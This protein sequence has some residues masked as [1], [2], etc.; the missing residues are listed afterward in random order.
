MN[1]IDEASDTLLE[2][3]TETAQAVPTEENTTKPEGKTDDALAKY[4]NED[5]EL[6]A[7]AVMV[8]LRQSEERLEGLRKKLAD[9]EVRTKA[10]EP[11]PEKAVPEKTAPT[12]ADEMKEELEAI[13][14]EKDR[15]FAE[16]FIGLLGKNGLSKE[17]ANELLNG[18][19]ELY[20]PEDPKAFFQNEMKKLGKGGK[21][22]LT[23][24]RAFRDSMRD[25]KEFGEEE[26]ASLEQI[27]QTADGV[28]LI[29]RV[30]EKARTMDSGKFS[31]ARTG[32]FSADDFSNADRIK[33]YEKAFALR[34]T[35]P[36]ESEAEIARLDRMF[37]K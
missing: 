14:D 9:K 6:D 33:M 37:A 26:I 22:V 3:A 29:D 20:Q 11:A 12:L 31:H 2:E 21:E 27:T 5:G 25:S 19:T 7:D 17:K 35:N 18:L 23:R 36:D 13:G 15:E 24:V 8:A 32:E 1:A 34:R 10:K 30:L 4:R 28:R 16:K